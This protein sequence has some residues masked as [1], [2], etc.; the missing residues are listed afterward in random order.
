M[1]NS[2]ILSGLAA[3]LAA[4]AP[5]PQ[6]MGLDLAAIKAI[7]VPAPTGAPVA[8]AALSAVPTYNTVAAASAASATAV[9]TEGASKRKRDSSDCQPLPAGAGPVATPDT[10]SAFLSSTT[11]Y[12]TADSADQPQGYSLAFS[13]S[14]GSVSGSVYMGYYTLN[15]YDT[16]ACAHYCDAADGCYGMLPHLSIFV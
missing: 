14:K 3:G 12:N 11:I 16:V 9:V 7:N 4:A 13:N 10:D 6:S 15:S 5:A 8:V 2:I 1:R